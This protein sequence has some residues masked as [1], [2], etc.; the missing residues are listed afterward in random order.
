MRSLTALGLPGVRRGKQLCEPATMCASLRAAARS[1]DGYPYREEPLR[2]TEQRADSSPLTT[3]LPG[4]IS[5]LY[6]I[7]RVPAR[8]E[9]VWPEGLIEMSPNV[10]PCSASPGYPDPERPEQP[11]P[12]PPQPEEPVPQPPRPEIPPFGPEE[13]HL[14][15]PDPEPGPR[16]DPLPDPRG[17]GYSV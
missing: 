10:Q 15:P 11:E 16:P 14:P 5:R 7:V 2:R 1:A 6:L 12:P 9:T 3:G 4:L 13:P 8:G 17:P